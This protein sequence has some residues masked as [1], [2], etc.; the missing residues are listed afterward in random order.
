MTTLTRRIT[1]AEHAL[2]RWRDRI[3]PEASED[4]VRLGI[5]RSLALGR[6][7]RLRR[8]KERIRKAIWHGANLATYLHYGPA[9]LVVV[10]DCVVSVYLYE[11][12][13]WEAVP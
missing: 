11:R 7:V 13:R 1:I 12:I 9:V 4:Q 10:G 8:E 5:A 2:L 6:E 3:D